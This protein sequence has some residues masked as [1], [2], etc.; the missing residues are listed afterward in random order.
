MLCPD[1]VGRAREQDLLRVRVG[2]LAERRGGV[3]ALVGEAGAREVA[4]ARA[5]ADAAIADGLPVLSGRAVPGASPL[6]YRPLTEAFLAAFRADGATRR[7]VAGGLRQ[8]P[9][10]ARPGVARRPAGGRGVAGAAGRGGGAPA[11]RPRCRRRR[12]CSC[13]R[14]CTGPTPRRSAVVEYLADALRD[15]AGALP[16]APAGRTATPAS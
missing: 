4:L 2:D 8:P 5:T 7:S 11:R 12:A 1:L 10:P 16:R 9:R 14:T 6:A 13:S 3:V 15:R